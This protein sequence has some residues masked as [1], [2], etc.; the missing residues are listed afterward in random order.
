VTK[1]RGAKWLDVRMKGV[2]KGKLK[3]K[4]VAKP[5]HGRIRVVA[6]I[7]QSKR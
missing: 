6:K 5:V 1:K 3:F 2:H 4:I 7:R